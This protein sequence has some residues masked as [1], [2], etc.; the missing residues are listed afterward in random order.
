MSRLI[1][2]MLLWA[3]L[4]GARAAE[5]ESTLSLPGARSETYK[6]AT[7]AILKVHIF[8]PADGIAKGRPAIVFFFGGGWNGGSPRQ[9]EE[10]CRHFA[11]RGM[12]AMTADYRVRS[13]HGVKAVT[14]VTDAKS[15]IR[16]V[17]NNATRLGIDPDRIVAAG[18]SA[19]GHLA[20]ATATIKAF[21]EPGEQGSGVSAV[22][23]AL[24]LFNPALVLAPLGDA[25]EDDFTR[26]LDK[27]RMGV[28]PMELSPAHH[29]ERGTPPAIIFHGTADQTV[30]FKTAEVFC[31][32][33][34]KAGNRCEL[35]PFAGQ[36]HGFF[37]NRRGDSRYYKETLK[38]ADD[39]LVSIGYLQPPKPF[40]TE[41][42]GK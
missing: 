13:R 29:V 34:K 12:M 24:V 35:V 40:V 41:G 22:P 31:A 27:D 5:T 9:F 19:G 4:N 42:S 6:T 1:L 11:S 36:G 2:M 3:G 32:A 25:G 28:D 15:C 17:R 10:H 33:M 18:G 30:P 38:A 20:A 8:E 26:R 21:D 7:N 23:N 16:W 14:C 37:N 39:F